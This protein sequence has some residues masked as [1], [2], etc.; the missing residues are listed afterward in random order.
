M[1]KETAPAGGYHLIRLHQ[2][3]MVWAAFRERIIRFIDLRCWLALLEMKHRR[4]G[5]DGDR[6][7]YGLDELARLVGSKPDKHLRAAAR[8]L[9]DA[10][11]ARWGPQ[12]LS[13]AESP[14]S[15]PT[16]VLDAFWAMRS[17]V[18]KKTPNRRIPVPRR[19]LREMASGRLT[20]VQIATALGGLVR[21]CWFRKDGCNWSGRCSAGWIATVFGCERARVIEARRTLITAGWLAFDATDTLHYCRKRWGPRVVVVVGLAPL[22]VATVAEK[23]PVYIDPDPPTETENPDPTE[24]GACAKTPRRPRLHDIATDH[25]KDIDCLDELLQQAVAVG[26]VSDSEDDRLNVVCAAAHALR[27]GS[28]PPALFSWLIR[29]QHWR[30]ISNADEDEALRLLHGPH[31]TRDAED[32]VLY[33]DIYA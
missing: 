9:E 12:G 11:L 8:R 21:C 29:G 10:G 14:E 7:E 30:T 31:R 25:L 16:G 22:D 26:W 6:P 4:H 3:L 18:G 27:C 33:A 17:A 23:A 5:F 20:R 1:A 24:S 32:E 13:V 19:L 2:L 28:D 15:L